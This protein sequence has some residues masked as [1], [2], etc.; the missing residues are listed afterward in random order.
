MSLEVLYSTVCVNA[1]ISN[2]S[3]MYLKSECHRPVSDAARYTLHK[4]Q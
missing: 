3:K 2:A 1:S 4:Y